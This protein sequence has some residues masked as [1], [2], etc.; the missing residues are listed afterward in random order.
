MGVSP[1]VLL[2]A[3]RVQCVNREIRVTSGQA[4]QARTSARTLW[5]I[6]MPAVSV[7]GRPYIKSIP[8]RA[9]VS[10]SFWLKRLRA[11]A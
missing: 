9:G 11:R 4:T 1:D 2:G 5:N 10:N 6:E 3:N 8:L 7:R